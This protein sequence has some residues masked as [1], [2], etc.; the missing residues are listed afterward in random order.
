MLGD[1]EWIILYDLLMWEKD[2]TMMKVVMCKV[3]V[4]YSNMQKK[5]RNI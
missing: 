5:E 2:A 4:T 3:L 1:N